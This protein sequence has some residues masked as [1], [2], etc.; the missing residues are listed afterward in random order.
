[1]S[2]LIKKYFLTELNEAEDEALS[3][4]LLNFPEDSLRFEQLAKTAYFRYGLPE[5]QWPGG[6]RTSPGFHAFGRPWF[7]IVLALS[8][9]VLSLLS[10]RHFHAGGFMPQAR[11]SLV[12][13]AVREKG[14]AGATSAHIAAVVPNPADE[15]PVPSAMIQSETQNETKPGAPETSGASALRQEPSNTVPSGAVP[16]PAEKAVTTAYQ[17]MLTPVD[18]EVHPRQSH[19]DLSVI[20]HKYDSGAVTIRVADADGTPIAVLF[21]GPL[22]KGKWV[23]D[24]DGRLSDGNAVNPGRYQILVESGRTIQKKII[25]IREKGL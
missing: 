10:W 9:V 11:P 19:S 21:Q 23:F 5:P 7:W 8:G 16:G 2:D 24:W 15:K 4:R 3:E 1:L 13:D 12:S 17:P 20:V 6:A 18:L 14:G 22:S 25:V